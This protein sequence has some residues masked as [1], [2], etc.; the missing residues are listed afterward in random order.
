M[1]CWLG[2]LSDTRRSV[3]GYC[4]FLGQSLI[5]WN[6]KKQNIV[7]RSFAEAEYKS[8]AVV[9]SK[10]KW[11]SYLLEDFQ[12]DL[13]LFIALHCDNQATIYIAANPVFHE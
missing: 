1:W 6:T 9:V 5:S 13:S 7:S 12:I 8:M 4:V 2:Y 11:I 10:L 3:N